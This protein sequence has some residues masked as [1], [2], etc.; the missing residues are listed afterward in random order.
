MKL[1]W[2]IILAISLLFNLGIFYVAFKALEYRRHINDFLEKY[3]YVVSEFSGRDR[4]ADAN[5][6]LIRDN[7]KKGR[8]VF[9]G[10]QITEGWDLNRYFSDY[11]AIN[12]GIS[13]QRVAGYLLR[14]MPDVVDLHPGA[15]VI[16]FSSY[17]FRPENSI[18]EI[19]DYMASA[20]NIA[21]SNNIMPIFTTI[22]PVREDFFVEGLDDYSVND[23][24]RTYNNWLRGYCGIKNYPMVD[25][26]NLLVGGDGNLP[27]SLSTSQIQLND[28]GYGI[29]SGAVMSVLDSLQN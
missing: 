18:R 15:V 29:V 9:I 13:G 3:T 4:Y 12:R 27:E 8:V 26:Y 11:Q 22:V 7:S 20:G 25:F 17:N 1:R 28:K 6:K 19:C 5:G 24:L 23:S 10:S 2:K 14:F 16:E 21:T